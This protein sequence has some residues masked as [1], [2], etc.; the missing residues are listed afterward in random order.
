[1][2]T[3]CSPGTPSRGPTS[4]QRRQTRR[5]AAWVCARERPLVIGEV[6]ATGCAAAAALTSRRS[7]S[8]RLLAP[9]ARAQVPQERRGAGTTSSRHIARQSARAASAS[10]QHACM[11]A[12]HQPP[13][14]LA[15]KEHRVQLGHT[16]GKPG[17]QTQNLVP[18]GLDDCG[19]TEEVF[20]FFQ[21]GPALC[22]LHRVPVAHQ[23][24]VGAVYL[25]ATRVQMSRSRAP[26]ACLLASA[27][28]ALA[29][30]VTTH[31]PCSAESPF[32]RSFSSSSSH[33]AAV[34]RRLAAASWFFFSQR[35]SASAN[36]QSRLE[37]AN[38]VVHTLT[39]RAAPRCAAQHS[40]AQH[41]TAQHST[42]CRPPHRSFSRT[43]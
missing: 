8:A 21:D 26:R 3:C 14:E 6:L 11:R 39:L 23:T 25:R 9:R 22:G 35:R 7:R 16:S 40:T 12:T 30:S 41:S 1:M 5:T 2:H 36:T 4:P 20:T 18:A 43:V 34:R 19:R 29:F 15:V 24:Q 31:R 27:A 13:E 10:A 17:P 28:A 32:S 37:S 42:A 33:W 38:K